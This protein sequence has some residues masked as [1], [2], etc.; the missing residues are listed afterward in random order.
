MSEIT[1]YDENMTTIDKNVKQIPKMSQKLPKN[2]Q[3]KKK[4]FSSFFWLETTLTN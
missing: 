1:K 4:M 2:G 3:I